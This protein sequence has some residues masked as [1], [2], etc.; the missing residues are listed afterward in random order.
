[1]LVLSNCWKNHPLKHIE[2]DTIQLDLRRLVLTKILGP[3]LSVLLIA[4]DEFGQHKA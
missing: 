3:F 2:I 4:T 1:V